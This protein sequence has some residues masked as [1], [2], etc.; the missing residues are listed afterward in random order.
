MRIEYR[1][2]NCQNIM[3]AFATQ[4]PTG[5]RPLAG[6]VAVCLKCLCVMKVNDQEN[7]LRGMSQEEWEIIVNDRGFM[8][9]MGQLI[10]DVRRINFE[11]KASLN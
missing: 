10:H 9:L 6:D 8:Q 2:L 1:C 4:D 7:G 11:R 5:G 3:N